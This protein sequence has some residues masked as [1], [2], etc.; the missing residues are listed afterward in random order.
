M[1]SELLYTVHLEEHYFVL[2]DSDGR[3]VDYSRRPVDAGEALEGYLIRDFGCGYL[4]EDPDYLPEEDE[5]A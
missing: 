5:D 2:R 3:T 1:S 4:P